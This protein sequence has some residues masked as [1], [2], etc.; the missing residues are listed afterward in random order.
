MAL[1]R[2]PHAT[3][4]AAHNILVIAGESSLVET[5]PEDKKPSRPNSNNMNYQGSQHSKLVQRKIFSPLF[6]DREFANITESNGFSEIPIVLVPRSPLLVSLA[7]NV[8]SG[9]FVLW[10]KWHRNMGQLA[11]GVLWVWP[12]W[13]RISHI[14]TRATITYNAPT[15][16]CPTAD[17]GKQQ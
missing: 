12:G 1:S 2:H 9:P 13:C 17:N 3:D 6:A 16:N 8:P 4:K 15:R 5:T 7:V 10:Q 11:P 14:I